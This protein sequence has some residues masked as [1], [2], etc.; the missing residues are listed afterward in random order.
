MGNEW[1]IHVDWNQ[2]L[3]ARVDPLI[4]QFFRLK[5]RKQDKNYVI[6]NNILSDRCN[7]VLG[8]PEYIQTEPTYIGNL[9]PLV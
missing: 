2:K 9:G 8:P 1:L 4:E 6:D 7:G 3:S 5:N